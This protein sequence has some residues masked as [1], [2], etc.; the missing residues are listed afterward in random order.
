[1]D[2][3][4]FLCP[5]PH[6]ID[7]KPS[8]S[9]PK[10]LSLGA[11][12]NVSVA[13]FSEVSPGG[14]QTWD[15][16]NVRKDATLTLTVGDV[17]HSVKVNAKGQGTCTVKDFADPLTGL[18]KPPKD[19]ACQFPT[20][21]FPLGTHE[22]VVAGFFLDPASGEILRFQGRQEITIVP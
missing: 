5:Q 16:A 20:S 1:V 22:A 19:G 3:G 6:R 15:F 13:I 18:K 8:F 21:G 17:T 2:C 10:L 12:A 14:A 9:F 4:A 11:E 7:V